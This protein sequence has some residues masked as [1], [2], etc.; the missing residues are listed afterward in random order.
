MGSKGKS[1]FETVK[2]LSEEFF[3]DF[4]SQQVEES[5]TIYESFDSLKSVHENAPGLVFVY[6]HKKLGYDYFSSNAIN[7]LGY[8]SKQFL[9]GGLKF[10]MSLVDEEHTK[11]YNQ[12]I[13]PQ[14]F[15]YIS[16]YALKRRILDLRLCYTFKIKKSSGEYMWAMH[17][18]NPLEKNIIGFPTRFL[19]FVTDVT[20][21]KSDEFVG[22][23]ASVKDENSIYKSVYSCLYPAFKEKLAFS[24]REL[25]ILQQL[26][27]GKTSIAIASELG[28][29]HHTVNTHRKR[30]LEK[31]NSSNT[32]EM[33]QKSYIKGLIHR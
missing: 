8:E 20:P 31:T 29:S 14:M 19:V 11:I 7:I 9:E 12:H 26:C 4:K 5:Q 2:D 32:A 25:D 3:E 21:F 15:K 30:M 1:I 22:F 28:I 13:I 6:N 23:T 33:L 24:E 17:T 10:A 16:T 27:S 18:M